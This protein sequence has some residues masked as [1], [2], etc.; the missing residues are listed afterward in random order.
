MC[1]K[2]S[3]V[4]SKA[5]PQ[6]YISL[7]EKIRRYHYIC[8]DKQ[9]F[10]FH[11]CSYLF[12]FR[13]LR[14]FSPSLTQRCYSL[15]PP[16]ITLPLILNSDSILFVQTLRHHSLLVSI[17]IPLILTLRHHFLSPLMHTFHLI[18]TLQTVPSSILLFP[19]LGIVSIFWL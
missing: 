4:C 3:F 15:S 18:W 11:C 7:S 2:T 5:T 6:Y 9:G 10:Q 13:N 14:R 19:S 16:G 17:S 12:R 1:S 8:L